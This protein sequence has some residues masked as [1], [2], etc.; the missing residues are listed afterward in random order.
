MVDFDRI[1]EDKQ[2]RLTVGATNVDTGNF[3]YFDSSRTRIGV[4]HIM[5]SGALPPAFAPVRIGDK[6][7]WDGGLVST[8][9]L[10]HIL[11]EWPRQDTLALQ[12]DLWSARAERPHNMM[13]VLARAKD[14]QYSSR[15]RH[16]TD[17]VARTQHL[18]AALA[19]LIAALPEPT[20][21]GALQ[22]NLPPLI[23]EPVFT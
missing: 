6:A 5:A 9:P 20:V 1:H 13:D 14:M 11:G 8:T 19:E 10:E 15:T 3:E 12:V 2:V 22:E 4:E 7:Y 18:R 21:P 17:T 16:G 23:A